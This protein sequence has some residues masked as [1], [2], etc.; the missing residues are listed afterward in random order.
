MGKLIHRAQELSNQG[1]LI[2]RENEN[3]ERYI[4]RLTGFS[5]RKAYYYIELFELVSLYPKLKTV[6]TGV[7]SLYGE[8]GQK[9]CDFLEYD[10][11]QAKYWKTI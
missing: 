10:K 5:K 1:S 9:I 2:F 7:S 11:E 3:F 6:A 4:K 8:K